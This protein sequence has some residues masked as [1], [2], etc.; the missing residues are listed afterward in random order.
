MYNAKI[1]PYIGKDMITA[2]KYL[3]AKFIWRTANTL[4]NDKN[5]ASQDEILMFDKMRNSSSKASIRLWYAF[6]DL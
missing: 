3:D 4:K 5:Q 1:K 2:S 6:Y